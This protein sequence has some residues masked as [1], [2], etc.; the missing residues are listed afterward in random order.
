M[1]YWTELRT[2]LVLAKLGTV[3]ATAKE[4]GIHRVTVNRHIDTLDAH[5]G[6]SLFQRHARGYTLTEE[7]Q[8]MF[9]VALRAETLFGELQT[10]LRGRA[11]AVSGKLV[12]TAIA[13]IAPTVMAAIKNFT[14]AHPDIEI[15]YQAEERLAKLEHGEAHIA[16]RAGEKPEEPDYV[17]RSHRPIRFALY[18]SKDYVDRH[19]I[20]DLNALDAHRFVAPSSFHTNMPYVRWFS[21]NVGPEQFALRTNSHLVRR[22]AICHGVGLGFLDDQEAFIYEDL[23]EIMRLDEDLKIDIWVVTHLDLRRKP[24]V[25]AFLASLK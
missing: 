11:S 3:S 4:I 23:V 1:K 7:G 14:V 21:D 9:D 5:F 15:E 12:I 2:A 20:P 17:V 25:Q 13:A 18:A 8:D 16:F 19:G 24:K 10:Q 22:I 6:T